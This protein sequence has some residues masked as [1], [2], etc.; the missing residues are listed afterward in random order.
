MTRP[1]AERVSPAD[2]PYNHC[3]RRAFLC[4]EDKFTD[5]DY[6]HRKAWVLER[7][8]LLDEVFTIELCAYAVI[9]HHYH[10]VAHLNSKKAKSLNDSTKRW[11]HLVVF[12]RVDEK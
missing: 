12:L 1:R 11:L 3:V 6:S 7:F 10:Q 5:T 8:A 9:S 2:T 4:G